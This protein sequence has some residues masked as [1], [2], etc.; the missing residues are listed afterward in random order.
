MPNDVTYTLRDGKRVVI[1]FGDD[2]KPVSV[3]GELAQVW[4]KSQ[5]RITDNRIRKG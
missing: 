4:A 1:R 2:G 5:G 3:S